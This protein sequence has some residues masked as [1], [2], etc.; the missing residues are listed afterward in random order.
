MLPCAI[1]FIALAQPILSMIYPTASDGAG[2]FQIASV[3]MILT[4]LSQTMT[5]GLY[6]GKPI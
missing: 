3:S 5:G 2:V 6:G 4:A 1:G